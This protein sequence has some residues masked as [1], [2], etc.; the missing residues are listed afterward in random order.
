[1]R[2][3]TLDRQ[4][5]YDEDAMGLGQIL[6]VKARIDDPKEPAVDVEVVILDIQS[7]YLF[8]G[9]AVQGEHH[10]SVRYCATPVADILFA[11]HDTG[12]HDEDIEVLVAQF[13]S[14]TYFGQPDARRWRVGSV[15]T[16]QGISLRMISINSIYFK[17]DTDPEN[18]IVT[19][20]FQAIP[21]NLPSKKFLRHQQAAQRIQNFRLL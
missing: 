4:F 16:H 13:D 19:L 8:K 21:L 2:I 15:F 18:P 1:M 9:E 12:T 14:K 7:Y 3:L 20:E 10:L 6:N 5:R 11:Q 17:P